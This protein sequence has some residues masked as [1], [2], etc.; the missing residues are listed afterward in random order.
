MGKSS[1]PPFLLSLSTFSSSSSSSSSSKLKTSNP[2]PPY[3]DLGE[4]I[5]DKPRQLWR[6][7][8]KR[9]GLP[10]SSDVGILGQLIDELRH[11][12]EARLGHRVESVV[13]TTLPLFGLYDEDITDALELCGLISAATDSGIHHH[14]HH[15]HQPSELRTAFAGLG[16]GLA[17]PPPPPPSPPS[18]P[19][20]QQ[21]QQQQQILYLSFSNDSLLVSVGHGTTAYDVR[22]DD[23]AEPLMYWH[24]GAATLPG[25]AHPD[26]YWCRIYDAV[27]QPLTWSRIAFDHIILLGDRAADTPFVDTVHAAL[28]A[29]PLHQRA[30]VH[31][32]NPR[33]LAARGAA[34]FA[35]RA[36][37]EDA[38]RPISGSSPPS[39]SSSA[40]SAAAAVEAEAEIEAEAE[41][42]ADPRGGRGKKDV[43]AARDL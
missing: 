14:H 33:S 43:D 22:Q 1:L 3:N 7:L 5:R 37:N 38:S 30:D 42:E 17:P 29:F 32:L 35:L 28:R 11:E 8:R 23:N 40:S 12:T 36:Q 15:H 9:M 41:A 26:D 31:L 27:A 39:P 18:P 10:A 2:S 25:Y 24:L 34:E 4:E 21:Q 16:L 20:Q 13:V 6:N 19:P